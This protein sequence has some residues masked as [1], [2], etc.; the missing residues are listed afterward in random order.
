M[1][2]EYPRRM[3]DAGQW[4]G[5]GTQRG[6]APG[7][8]RWWDLG[9]AENLVGARGI[10]MTKRHEGVGRGERGFTARVTNA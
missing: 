9:V 3:D 4:I 2:K 7:R 8:S 6:G 1:K 10:E 5:Y